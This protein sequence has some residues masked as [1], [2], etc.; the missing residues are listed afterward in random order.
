MRKLIFTLLLI[1][2][3]AWAQIQAWNAGQN[4]ATLGNSAS[5][6]LTGCSTNSAPFLVA[7]VSIQNMG[8]ATGVTISST[9]IPGANW[10]HKTGAVNG[11]TAEALFWGYSGSISN[12]EVVTV[13]GSVWQAALTVQ[14]FSGVNTTFQPDQYGANTCGTGSNYVTSCQPSTGNIAPSQYGEMIVAGSVSSMSSPTQT[15]N[16]G[17][18]YSMSC[19]SI[20]VCMGYLIQTTATALNPTFS[21]GGNYGK[22]S[23]DIMTFYAAGAPTD[24]TVS[25]PGSGYVYAAST[26]FTVTKSAGT[27]TGSTTIT[28][29]DGGQGGTITAASYCTG[30][31]IAPVTL[32]PTGGQSTCTFT[33]TP[34][35]TGSLALSLTGAGMSGSNSLPV[36]YTSNPIT[37][38]NTCVSYT[39]IVGSASS[40]CTISVSGT[41]FNGSRSI[42][43]TDS[44]EYFGGTFTP[45]TGSPFTSSGTVTP[46]SAS[47]FTYTYTPSTT[48][49]A[50]I[51]TVTNNFLGANPANVT[52]TAT[53]GD[54]CTFTAKA[55]GPY[56]S[57]S[58]WTPS[59][60]TGGG[61]TTPTTGDT[62][63]VGAYS[64][65]CSSG[66][67]YAGTAPAN[68]TTYNVTIASG[69]K[70]EVSSGATFL[71]T[72]NYKLNSNA[73]SNPAVLQLDTGATFIVDNN[74]SATV[75]YRG[76]GGA[77]T[78]WNNLK[79]GSTGDVCTTTSSYTW[80]CPTNF[81]GVNIRGGI[82]PNLFEGGGLTDM[83]TY[84]I[85]G[86]GVK[87]CGTAAQPCLDYSSNGGSN[88]YA[89][90]GLINV[91]NSVFDTTSSLGS[92][93][94]RGY[95]CSS[96]CNV[97]WKNNKHIRDIAGFL[98]I[99]DN[100]L[101]QV[102]NS[103]SISGNYFDAM[104]GMNQNDYWENCKFVNNVF[105]HGNTFGASISYP[106]GS[107][108]GNVRLLTRGRRRTIR[109][110]CRS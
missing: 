100:D 87:N 73:G 71:L 18:S 2:C 90:A 35:T 15:I 12:S 32:I 26:V 21:I 78:D 85:F 20:P 51:I 57:A 108:V 34:A 75:S 16:D 58:T 48:V 33:Y 10:H 83:V 104:V 68:N 5:V 25:G 84:Q 38:T 9:S 40:T 3:P 53:S 19:A 70:L 102:D 56:N 97:T 6:T 36:S 46:A 8:S 110:T 98:G 13:S 64:V 109:P 1:S 4:M 81:L 88:G 52:Y 55:S 95:H 23:L 92:S 44:G 69:G 94:Q 54:V 89:N 47:S 103:C 24:Y 42:T 49:G 76:I 59:G 77:D 17:F 30:S 61:H 99:D 80:S 22:M 11:S 41:T 91:E 67:C 106:W 65:T 39:G 50:R 63:V 105:A 43:L 7:S 60:C 86:T 28:V 31:G 79:F 72:G 96:I 37:I 27:F 45:S 74:N 14:C 82:N 93:A 29:S 107:W 62:V 101:L 66:T